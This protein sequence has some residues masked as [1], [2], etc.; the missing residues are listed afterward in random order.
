MNTVYC[1]VIDG[2]IDGASCF[3][4]VLVANQEAKSTILPKGIKWNDEQC[5]I[6]K[7]CKYHSDIEE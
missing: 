5:R 7:A 3:D 2:Q 4:I 1:P 6:C